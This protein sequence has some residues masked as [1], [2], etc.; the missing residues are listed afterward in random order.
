MPCP[1]GRTGGGRV[2]LARTDVVTKRSARA[3]LTVVGGRGE[4]TVHLLRVERTYSTTDWFESVAA[5]DAEGGREEEV[6]V[7]GKGC[8][9]HLVGL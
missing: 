5:A 9:A 3:L 6:V 4:R 1:A 7:G 8:C 2:V